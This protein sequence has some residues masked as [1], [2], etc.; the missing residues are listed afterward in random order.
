VPSKDELS[1]QLA[2]TTKLAA[3]VERMA[4]AAEKLEGSYTAQ[5]ATLGQLAQALSQLNVQ[6][7][8]QG[9]QA[10]ADALKKVK[11]GLDDTSRTGESVFKKLGKKVEE[12]SKQFHDKF[13]KSVGIATGA[14]SGLSQGLS[15]IIA[16]GKGVGGFVT[17]FISG[18]GNITASILAIPI[19][20]FSGLID[21]AAQSAGGSNEL[22]QALEDLRKEFGAFYGPTNKAIIDTSKSMTGFKD[23]G[24]STWRVF[25]NMADRLKYIGELAKDMG[26]SFSKLRAEMENNGGAILGYQKGLGLAGEEMKAVTM[27]ST[28]MG[29]KTE[30]NLRD[31]TKYSY[32]LGDAFSLDAKLISRDMGKAL[33]DVAHFG[34]ATV[35]QIAE[36]STYARKLG[37]ELKDIT[38]TLDAFDTFDTAAENAAKLSQAM[39][40]QVDAFE[41]MSAQSPAEQL[42]MLRK[43]FA[44]A[45]V[46]ASQFNRAQLKLVASTTGLDEATVQSAL[47]LK[48]Q[49]LSMDQVQKKSVM[50]EKKTL[51]QAE[52]M[53]KLADAIERMVFSG[54]GMEGGFWKMFVAGIGRGIMSSQEFV[55]LMYKIRIALR[56]VMYI[57]V[58]LGRALVKIVPGFQ[59]V[60]KAL[61]EMF[62]PKKIT[63]LFKG[64]SEAIEKFL[65]KPGMDPKN[66]SKGSIPDLVM[67][68]K[69]TFQNF[70]DIE[71][72]G[73][74]KLVSGFKTFFKFL[75]TTAAAGIKY[76]A[77][78][79]A[80]GARE[81]VKML[82][83]PGG[84]SA[85][86]QGAGATAKGGLGF[87]QEVI[88]PLVDALKHA[89]TVLAPA[90]ESLV[91]T[92][93][94]L[95]VQFMKKHQK[96]IATIAKPVLGA[97]AAMLFGP[98][99]GRGI[100][101]ALGTTILKNVIPS[102]TKTVIQKAGASLAKSTAGE[103][104]M[105]G[106]SKFAGP[107][108]FVAAAAAV[109]SGVAKYTKDVTST[110]DRSSAVIAAGTT[111][112]IDA[113]TLGLL[114]DDLQTTIANVLAK[115]VDTLFKSIN[116]AFG[117]GFGNSLKKALAGA[118]EVFGSVWTVLTNLFTGDQASINQSM[119]D[120]GL[121]VLR[122]LVGAVNLVFI[123]LPIVLGKLG[124]Q[125]FTMIENVVLGLVGS[126]ASSMA[127]G[128][129]KVFGTDF[130]K[131]IDGFTDSIKKTIDQKS[132]QM[133]KGMSDVSAAFSQASDE[134]QDKYLRSEKDK[135]SE[136][137]RKAAA[138]TKT[139]TDATADA[140]RDA[141][142]S[143]TSVISQVSENISAVKDVQKQLDDKNFDIAGTLQTIKD[144]LSKVDFNVIND[145][146]I[147]SLT[148]LTGNSKLI[149]DT[150]QGFEQ[151]M[152]ALG[153]TLRGDGKG[154]V[155]G[156]LVAIS[157][158]VKA[159][160]DL[161]TALQGLNKDFDVKA[162]LDQ[163]AKTVG[164]GGKVNYQVNPSRNVQLNINLEVTMDVDKVEKVMILRAGSIVRD[165]IDFAT[166][167]P[168]QKASN[169]LSGYTP[170]DNVPG[171]N[172]VGA[173]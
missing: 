172:P 70:F 76:L 146:Q 22:M 154:G 40:V 79:I 100:L 18:L 134:I 86:A 91:K 58:D 106:V 62:D 14:I 50:A 66:P 16:V 132:D 129:D 41:M 39:G 59:E 151:N 153:S 157:E 126:L 38:G 61:N 131:K 73:A 15:N 103:G 23:T 52:A 88:T 77:D 170:S 82:T 17:S 105:K 13:P 117:T 120:L 8:V 45:G 173:G 142:A 152:S 4:A 48:N 90:L 140:A 80:T 1:E 97:L 164:L 92:M 29:T 94:R 171:P 69:K 118:F 137:A 162:K 31:M 33:G 89:W 96:E 143:T 116:S 6:G 37:F 65:G 124:I 75:S 84:L 158:M 64:V 35:K 125:L 109:G 115:V 139:T 51:T 168:D 72:P 56:Q 111:G 12:S 87:L 26:G 44:K 53:S 24:L 5:S 133:T 36:A 20:I 55:G 138:M 107:A 166:S 112:L 122:L 155:T 21:M 83:T 74:K 161:D 95:F 3:Q 10:L 127:S 7:S 9:V 78:E 63:S 27:R 42:D 121:S 150:L 46:D 47:S 113:L 119:K 68:L 54:G 67:N 159:S 165:R 148:K 128:L 2:L 135:A 108:A 101:G 81:I 60:G 34:G 57:G 147:A 169:P 99:F 43:S 163:V 85:Y 130:A 167:H 93:G 123:Q 149:S 30:K 110:L 32:E 144:K 19:K 71:K 160:N 141:A 28:A 98:A 114:P 145:D 49:G 102:L 25:G 11:G 104:L 156:A 136:A